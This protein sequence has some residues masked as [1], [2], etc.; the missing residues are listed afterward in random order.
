MKF[1]ER[2]DNIRVN[3][4]APGNTKTALLKAAE[5]DYYISEEKGDVWTTPDEV[6]SVMM[7]L[8]TDKEYV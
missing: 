2:A 4:V 5:R 3:A 1:L 7:K 6:A 8:V